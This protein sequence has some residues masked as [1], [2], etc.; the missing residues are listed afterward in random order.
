MV[1]TPLHEH[2]I[3]I[4]ITIAIIIIITSHHQVRHLQR[5]ACRCQVPQAAWRV[6]G[7]R[8]HRTPLLLMSSTSGKT[9]TINPKPFSPLLQCT[10]AH[11]RF[12]GKCRMWLVSIGDEFMHSAKVGADCC[13]RLFADEVKMVLLAGKLLA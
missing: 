11:P 1:R 2:F 12:C 9:K 7:M 5:R 3:T 13:N 4:T 10:P 6:L 8:A